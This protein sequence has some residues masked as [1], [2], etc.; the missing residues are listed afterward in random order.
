[1]LVKVIKIKFR[2]ER[3]IIYVIKDR[4]IIACAKSKRSI[5]EL[6]SIRERYNILAICINFGTLA[7][8]DS[9]FMPYLSNIAL[10]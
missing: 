4:K 6:Y 5:T 1:M 8:K 3:P 2:Y 7:R 10:V 9:H